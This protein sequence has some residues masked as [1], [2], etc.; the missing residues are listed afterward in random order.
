VSQLCRLHRRNG[1]LSSEV[2]EGSQGCGHNEEG[3]TERDVAF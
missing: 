3:Y 2:L 1:D